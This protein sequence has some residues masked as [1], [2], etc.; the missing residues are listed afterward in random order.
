M[1]G[2]NDGTIFEGCDAQG[3]L[4]KICIFHHICDLGFTDF[5]KNQSIA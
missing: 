5:I 3:L 4:K 2:L 1:T